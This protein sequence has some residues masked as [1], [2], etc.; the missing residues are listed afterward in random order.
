MFAINKTTRVFIRDDCLRKCSTT[1]S[2]PS[3]DQN[4]TSLAF[5]KAHA[6]FHYLTWYFK[7][8]GKE[9]EWKA[10][11]THACAGDPVTDANAA[12][13]RSDT[14][15]LTVGPT[16]QPRVAGLGC[17]P[18]FAAHGYRHVPTFPRPPLSRKYAALNAKAEAYAAAYNR[19]IR[20]RQTR[21]V[22][23]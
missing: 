22:R 12:M 2:P 21:T 15:L 18:A 3:P 4:R 19:T 5:R 20:L 11:L 6:P 13:D 9:V 8:G 16:W 14:R 17:P 1:L 7:G 23:R 10:R